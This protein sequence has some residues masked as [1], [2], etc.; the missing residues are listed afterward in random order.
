MHAVSIKTLDDGNKTQEDKDKKDTSGPEKP[1]DE[2]KKHAS[3]NKTH[4]GR[5]KK[6]PFQTELT[7]KNECYDQSK[8]KPQAEPAING[9]EDR[10]NTFLCE[11]HDR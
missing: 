4:E 2:N 9:A 10:Q 8:S 1:E 5:T 6:D 7:T 3:R 11:L